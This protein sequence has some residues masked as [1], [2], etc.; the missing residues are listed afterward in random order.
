[1]GR[2]WQRAKRRQCDGQACGGALGGCQL[3]L[4]YVPGLIGGCQR[5]CGDVEDCQGLTIV[6][7]LLGLLRIVGVVAGVCLST[8]GG[9]PPMPLCDISSGCGFSTGP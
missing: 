3:L 1:M 2:E 4:R 9:D 7:I 5:L 8:G 6:A